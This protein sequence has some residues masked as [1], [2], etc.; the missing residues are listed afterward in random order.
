MGFFKRLFLMEEEKSQRLAYR[1]YSC[2]NIVRRGI[3]V[4][5]EDV[6]FCLRCFNS[7]ACSCCRLPCGSQR[8]KLSDGRIICQ[9]CHSTA[10][11][12]HRQLVPMYNTTIRYFGKKL[13]MNLKQ[14]PPLRTVDTRFLARLGCPPFTFGL[15]H[16][17]NMGEYIYVLNGIAKEQSLVVL[18]HE[19]THFWQKS[20]CPPDQNLMLSEGFAVWTS[21]K[22]AASLNHKRAILSLK[23]NITEPYHTGLR[24]ML[25]LEQ[26]KG[27]RGLI[28][29]VKKNSRLKKKPG[30]LP[31]FSRDI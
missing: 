13:R 8:R 25:A 24:F 21:Y 14:H 6:A 22:L 3:L 2:N 29:F 15:Y 9:H 16:Q 31:V 1:C 10:L 12:S 17:G 27:S 7:T 30:Q 23:R 4:D 19:L 18:S 28:K 11:L 20:N 5:E 26:Q